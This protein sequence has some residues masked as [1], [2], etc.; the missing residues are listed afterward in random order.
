MQ[1]AKTGILG[2]A[3]ASAKKFADVLTANQVFIFGYPTSLGL[4]NIP[5]IDYSKPLLRSGIVAGTNQDLKT[6]ILDCPAYGGNS[7]GPVLEV[8]VEGLGRKY[9]VIGVVSEFVPAVQ[10]WRNSPQASIN[11]SVYNSGYTVATPMDFVLDLVAQ[12]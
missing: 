11:A 5:Q 12:F 10:T 8:E 6:I 7:G 4:K 1:I 9:R 2:V 3:Q